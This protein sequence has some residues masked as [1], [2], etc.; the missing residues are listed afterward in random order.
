MALVL[1]KI[2]DSDERRNPNG[3]APRDD[4]AADRAYCYRYPH[5]AI[6]ADCVIFGYDGRR[7]HILL[8]QRALKPYQGHWALPGGFMHIDETIEATAMRELYEETGLAGVYLEQFRVYS[9]VDRDPRERVV[10]VAF[11]ALVRP[12]NYELVAGD[13][14]DNARWFA[15]NALPPLAFD[16]EEIVSEARA[17]LQEMIRIRPVVSNLLDNVFAMSDLQRIYEEITGR[18]FDRRNFARKAV[19]SGLVAEVPAE[20]DFVNFC[21]CEEMP[22]GHTLPDGKMVSCSMVSPSDSS[23]PSPS[24]SKQSAALSFFASKG[25]MTAPQS[26]SQPERQTRGRKPSKLFTFLRPGKKDEDDPAE[27]TSLKDIF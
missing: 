23:L 18:N 4:N 16:H 19:Q 21:K 24:A 6:T 3:E 12:S 22:W 1:D 14:A 7:L 2:Y 20:D 5:A 27:D 17:Y 8:I 13:D 10:T 11:I 26:N 9:K 25:K 15:L